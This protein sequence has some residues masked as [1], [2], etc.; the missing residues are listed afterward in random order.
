MWPPQ[1]LLKRRL[2]KRLQYLE[3][4]DALLRRDGGVSLLKG[5][6][7][8]RLEHLDVTKDMPSRSAFLEV[9]R[10][11]GGEKKDW[12]K[13]KL[14]GEDEVRFSLFPHCWLFDQSFSS[15]EGTY[16]VRLFQ[17]SSITSLIP[18]Q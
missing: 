9:I 15:G 1:V 18:L 7:E 8:I 3:L 16:L 14:E 5:D 12:Q 11:L 10:L 17:C 2:K 6:E 13:I 4:D